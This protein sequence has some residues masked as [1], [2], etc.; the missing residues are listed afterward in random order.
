MATLAESVIQGAQQTAD[1]AGTVGDAV[2][3]YHIA[4]TAEHARQEL[5]MEKQKQ[6]M[7]KANWILGGINKAATLV[8]PIQKGYMKNF[9][10]QWKRMDP[11]ADTSGLESLTNSPDDLRG[12]LASAKEM[13]DR[14]GVSEDH[15]AAYVKG[16]GS[17]EGVQKAIDD[18]ANHRAMI[19]AAQTKAE[20]MNL[21]GQVM[22]ANAAQTAG[23]KFDKDPNL[24]KLLP[25]GQALGRDLSTISHNSSDHPVT[26]QTLHESLMNVANVLGSGSL[27]DSRVNSIT[28]HINDET[29]S[30]IE[31]FFGDDPNRAASPEYVNYVRNL[32]TRLHGAVKND[33][34]DRADQIASGRDT[35][36]AAAV[37]GVSE[38]TKAKHDYYR[39][40]QWLANQAKAA[41]PQNQVGPHGASVVQGGH[42]YTWNPQT[43]KY[44]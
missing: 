13:A 26:Y 15:Q 24:N 7:N 29:R 39:N 21:R 17:Y 9:A 40:G 18:Y 37:P 23:D 8:G 43:G 14:G 42:T 44:E 27:S 38:V 10:D 34:T 22:A 32:V 19:Q 30:K 1:K 6:D 20:G 12:Y 31:Q 33:V 25:M 11:T 3:A 4:A 35:I 28:P 36:A 2:Q 5:D 41:A 16:M